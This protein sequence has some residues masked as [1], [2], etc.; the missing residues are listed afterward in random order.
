MRRLCRVGIAAT[1]AACARV[2]APPA[3]TPGI[4]VDLRAP[5]ALVEEAPDRLALRL[6]DSPHGV[7][8][9]LGELPGT[10]PVLDGRTR[11]VAGWPMIAVAFPDRP[12]ERVEVRVEGIDLLVRFAGPP[13][14]ELA[15]GAPADPVLTWV[16]YRPRPEDWR[17]VVDGLATLSLPVAEVSRGPDGAVTVGETTL[18]SEAAVFHSG[19]D[20]GRWWWSSVPSLSAVDPYPRTSLSLPLTP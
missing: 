15:P 19:I 5:W 1:V 2:P 12:L 4:V 7:V 6:G 10:S 9:G 13:L 20:G 3:P 14:A 11:D 18:T 16:R 17:V 8:V